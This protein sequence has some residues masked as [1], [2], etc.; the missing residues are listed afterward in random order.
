MDSHC[1]GL[2]DLFIALC[3]SGH[4]TRTLSQ[5]LTYWF[6]F[7]LIRFSKKKRERTTQPRPIRRYAIEV[8]PR[9]LMKSSWREELKYR[10]PLSNKLHKRRKIPAHYLISNRFHARNF[11]AEIMGNEKELSKFHRIP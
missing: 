3:N 2:L 4:A 11:S 6:L 8:S 9:R 7:K 1:T 5:V 10:W